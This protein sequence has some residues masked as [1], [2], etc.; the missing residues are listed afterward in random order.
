[1]KNRVTVRNSS[2]SAKA[3]AS[4]A[5]PKIVML[6]TSSGFLPTRSP[7]GPPDRAP[8]RMPMLDHRNATVNA[9]PFRPQTC[10]SDGTDQAIEL[11][12]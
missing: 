12:S 3:L 5:S 11:M 4:E 1:M 2:E 7:I 6:A 8:T 9:D 10:V